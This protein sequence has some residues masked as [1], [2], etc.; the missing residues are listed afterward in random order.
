MVAGNVQSLC[1]LFNCNHV[2]HGL[3]FCAVFVSPIAK[4]LTAILDNDITYIISIAFYQVIT[5][6]DRLV[7]ILAVIYFV[8][9]KYNRNTVGKSLIC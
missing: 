3:V 1:A 7:F 6:S 8:R 2:I 5:Y 4:S 9:Y